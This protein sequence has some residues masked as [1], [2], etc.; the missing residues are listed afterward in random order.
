MHQP[1]SFHCK[2]S[3]LFVV[4]ANAYACERGHR[5]GYWDLVDTEGAVWY[6]HL[7]RSKLHETL[8]LFSVRQSALYSDCSSIALALPGRVCRCVTMVRGAPIPPTKI[9][10]PGGL[11]QHYSSQ[12]LCSQYFQLFCYLTSHLIL[13]I[14]NVRSKPLLASLQVE[15]VWEPS[16]CKIQLL[17]MSLAIAQLPTCL[18]P[19]KDVSLRTQNAR[20]AN[21]SKTSQLSLA[22]AR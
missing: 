18:L 4:V 19:T 7:T 8:R 21:N 14:S 15:K 2:A 12:Q 1:H 6:K 11:L 22:A 5:F 13:T 10:H 17:T 20:A 3:E 9:R 16:R